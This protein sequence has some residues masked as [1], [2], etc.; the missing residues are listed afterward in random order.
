MFDIRICN[1]NFKVETTFLHLFCWCFHLL[2]L[3]LFCSYW[4]WWTNILVLPIFLDQDEF[5]TR[6]LHINY[7]V[8]NFNSIKLPVCVINFY[9]LKIKVDLFV[10]ILGLVYPLM[11]LLLDLCLEIENNMTLFS[12]FLRSSSTSCHWRLL[13]RDN[14]APRVQ[15]P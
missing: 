9:C 4:Y 6:F 15:C 8:F 14:L 3:N 11:M 2:I 10:L 13:F 5:K 12:S 7:R 1:I